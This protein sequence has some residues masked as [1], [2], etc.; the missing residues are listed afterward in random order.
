MTVEPERIASVFKLVSALLALPRLEVRQMAMKPYTSRSDAASRLARLTEGRP[1]RVGAIYWL[2]TAALVLVLGAFFT[3]TVVKLA[4]GVPNASLPTLYAV[5]KGVAIFDRNNKFVCTVYADRDRIPVPLNHI[6]ANMRIAVLAAEDH[7]FYK[8]HGF[9]PIGIGRAF[10]SNMRAGHV[11]EGGSTITQQLVRNLYLNIH[12]RSLTRKLA[13]LALAVDVENKY[14]KDKILETYLNEVYFGNGVYGIE[15]AAQVYFNKHA[16]NLSLAESAF[17]AG[18]IKAPSDLGAPVNRDAAIAR[19]QEVLDKLTQYNFLNT[20]LVEQ[21]KHQR[22]RFIAGGKSATPYPYYM[23]YVLQELGSRLSQDQIWGKGLKVYTC[24]DQSAQKLAEEALNKG[25]MRAPAGINQGALVSESVR[26]GAVIALVGGVGDYRNHQWNRA[27]N[28]HTVGSSFKPFVYLAALINGAL[29]PESAIDDTPISFRMGFGQTYSPKNYDGRYLGLICARD[30]LVLS[31]NVCSIRVADAVGTNKV[32]ETARAAGITAPLNN[33]LT[34]ALG[35]CAVSPLEMATAYATLA[36]YGKYVTPRLIRSVDDAQGGKLA[37]FA[38]SSKEVLPS[39]QVCEIDDVLQDV[40]QRGTGTQARLNGI[41][42]AGKTGTADKAR[43]IWFV[44]FTPDTVTAVWGGNDRYLPVRGNVTGGMVMAK[45]WHDYMQAFYQ[46][47]P[48][49]KDSFVPPRT[50]LMKQSGIAIPASVLNDAA[51]YDEGV[52]QPS[53]DDTA[54]PAE[55]GEGGGAASEQSAAPQPEPA[56]TQQ[57]EEPAAT[58]GNDAGASSPESSSSSSSNERNEAPPMAPPFK[59]SEQA[60]PEPAPARSEPTAEPEDR[61]ARPSSQ[62]A[63]PPS[64]S[65]AP[66]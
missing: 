28:P 30:A 22:L 29:A 5:G 31:R 64:D 48:I 8:H 43:D 9:D 46:S 40:V 66:Q 25:I 57:R 37:E 65:G 16:S 60:R 17:I 61:S 14:S 33:N 54:P 20:G 41:A 26:D 11:V 24:L 1:S 44:G 35:S 21:A 50:P 62:Q 45:I 56:Q 13:E 12:D 4:Y 6:S 49:P 7:N 34:I 36:R 10:F 59:R 23:N 63:E 42:V 55:Q 32:I 3:L 15:R 2:A 39:E 51:N 18:L 52:K 53:E 47:H 19:Q 58:T 27:V 38:A